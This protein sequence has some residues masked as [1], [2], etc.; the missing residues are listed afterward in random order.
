MAAVITS[1]GVKGNQES[2]G[3]SFRLQLMRVLIGL[4]AVLALAAG[5]WGVL[6]PR[7]PL[8]HTSPA[9]VG[10]GVEVPGGL[11]RVD[12]VTPEHMAPMQ[13]D[14]FA[15]RGMS[16][17]GMGMDMAPAGYRRFA[18]E[19]TLAGRDTDGFHYSADQ[20][21]LAGNGMAPVTPHRHKLSTRTLARGSSASGVLL[22]QVPNDASEL[23]LTYGEGEQSV[24][25][26]LGPVAED[27][28]SHGGQ[29][30]HDHDSHAD[31]HKP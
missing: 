4:A 18:V 20:F 26:Q 25:L 16:M 9:R 31:D 19:V 21:R 11:F 8:G 28:H 3:G 13:N 12:S 14:K 1:N 10:D 6:A 22:F 17:S 23:R 2:A 15:Q 7:T 24:A 30:E 27:G 29:S 5:A